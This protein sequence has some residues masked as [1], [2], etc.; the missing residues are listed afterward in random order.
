MPSPVLRSDIVLRAR[1]RAGFDTTASPSDQ[2]VTNPE[3][4][5]MANES[6]TALYDLLIK[7]RGQEY[8]RT[9]L[10]FNTAAN[11]TIYLL[12]S[13]FY[14]LISV[15]AMG[16]A[17]V[18]K[19][20]LAP[21]ME[22]D[23]AELETLREIGYYT[24][25]NTRYRLGGVQGGDALLPAPTIELQPAPSGVFTVIFRYIPVAVQGDV[26]TDPFVDGI[27]GWDEWCVWD[28]AG[29]MLL[30]QDGNFG[31]YFS[32]RDSIGKRIEDLAG[33]RDAG[34]PELVV[35]TRQGLRYA[36]LRRVGGPRRRYW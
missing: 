4:L 2:F 9:E 11:Q 12:P 10:Q 33:Q 27:N 17:F 23:V 29:K 14:Q 30:K 13:N 5:R 1:A 31:P 35:D 26:S 25:A 21:F 7:A 3:I 6:I 34:S 18:G 28:I 24:P 19:V 15:R 20:P 22:R 8:Y 16:T 36:A 32:E